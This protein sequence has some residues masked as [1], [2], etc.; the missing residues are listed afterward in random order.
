MLWGSLRSQVLSRVHDD[1]LATKVPDWFNEVQLELLAAAQWRH[2]EATAFLPTTAPYST[3]TA[4][5]VNGS[6]VITFAGGAVIPAT[7]AGQLISVG[8]NYYKILSADNAQQVTLGS[9]F[10]GVTNAAL[11]FQIVFPFLSL[12]GDFS[13][14]RIFTAKL[15]GGVGDSIELDYSSEHDLFEFNADEASTN[16]RP[17]CYRFYQGKMVL[18][19]PPDGSYNVEVFYSR[20]PNTVDTSTPDSTA[21][22]WPDF[23]QYIL[24]QGVIAIGFEQ[25]DDSLAA[26]ARGRFESSLATAVSTNNRPPGVGGG[27]LKR[28]DRPMTRG[29]RL[30]YRVG[31][32][33]G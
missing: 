3:G 12:P 13:P 2:L 17:Y 32:P 5:A 4:S 22:D 16:G 20:I 24:L 8:G 21:L 9:N 28:W 1:S 31:D 25:I 10:I 14:P 27:K 30:P 6:T 19:P 29:G 26:A 33:I 15:N 18:F 23:A 11:A 7:A